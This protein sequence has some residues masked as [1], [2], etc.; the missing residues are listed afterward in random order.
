M[1]ACLRGKPVFLCYQ[2]WGGFHFPCGKPLGL[3][4]L[5]LGKSAALNPGEFCFWVKPVSFLLSL[6]KGLFK[7]V[8]GEITMVHRGSQFFRVS[9]HGGVLKTPR[10]F[11]KQVFRTWDPGGVPFSAATQ[12]S[13]EFFPQVLHAAQFFKPSNVGCCPLEGKKYVQQFGSQQTC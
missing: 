5:G 13:D 11:F 7:R 9:P 4:P 12:I 3:V 1:A 10:A 6:F 8:S 2:Q